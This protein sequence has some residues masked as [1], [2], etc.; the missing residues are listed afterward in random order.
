MKGVKHMLPGERRNR[1]LQL[2]LINKA[3]TVKELCDSLETSEA[4]IRRDLTI[5]EEEGKLERTHGGAV[6]NTD[7]FLDNEEIYPKKEQMNLEE[8]VRIAEKA[9][10]FIQDGDSI[11]IDSGTTTLELIKLIGKSDLKITVITNSTTSAALLA[12]NSNLELI[13]LGGKV[14]LKTLAVVGSTASDML[15]RLRVNKAFL[16]VNGINAEEGLMT[17]DLEEAEIKREMIHSAMER[18]VLT[19]H[20][21][22]KRLAMCRIA[23]VT[24]VDYVITD[25]KADKTVIEKIELNDVKVIRA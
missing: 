17:P 1:I 12:E 8:K 5:M 19:D 10:K 6:V 18:F 2:L 7:V 20:S 22:F 11:L 15:K 9:F 23:P 14:R 21:K 3:I 16:A 25:D 4:T 24:M 13:L